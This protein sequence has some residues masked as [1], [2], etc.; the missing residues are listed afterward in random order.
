MSYIKRIAGNDVIETVGTLHQGRPH[1][2]HHDRQVLDQRAKFVFQ[3]L[4]SWGIAAAFGDTFACDEHGKKTER[5]PPNELAMRACEIV[6][7]A[8]CELQHR[9]WIISQPPY[10]DCA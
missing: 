6:D 1:I 5:I 9:G 10:E 4:H 8:W 7:A 3:F 2:M